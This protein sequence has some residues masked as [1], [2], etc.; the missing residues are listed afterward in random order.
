MQHVICGLSFLVIPIIVNGFLAFL[1]QP[2]KAEKGKVYLP[3]FLLMIGLICSA[4]FI[5]PAIILAFLGK[6][7]ALAIVFF[8]F[9]LLSAS[10]IIA[11]KN[12][13]ISYEENGFVAKNFLGIK[14]SFTYD[15]VTA[16]KINMHETYIFAGK[17]K[18]MVDGFSIG[19]I[20]F[21]SMIRKRY[22]M[23]HNGQALPQIH[24]TKHDIFNGN[25]ADV[26]GFVF[27]YIFLSVIIAA[28]AIFFALE[29][30]VPNTAANTV[31]QQVSFTSFVAKGDEIVLTSS[32]NELYKI[33]FVGDEFDS[34]EIRTVC[35]GRT[36]VTVYS[37]EITPDDEENY[38]AIKAILNGDAYL[39]SFDETNRWHRE[40][41][42]PILLV[43]AI[44]AVL[45]GAFIAGSIIVGRNPKKFSKK[46]VRLFFQD[47]YV[48]Y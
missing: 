12:C 40:E 1:R 42:W 33:K 47:R 25:I 30:F 48:K 28:C 45:W 44:L 8:A 11:F 37:K 46:V 16:V 10:L 29:V 43:P 3:K 18:V 41:Y 34:T 31:E 24:K 2:S 9:S 21:I 17:R 32:D 4:F 14:R 6:H 19:K 26:G 20:E 36:S 39:L 15:Q 27:V 7:L 13:R 38:Y 35:D 23:I 5:I 22:R